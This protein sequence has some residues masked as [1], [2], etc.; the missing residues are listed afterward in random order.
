VLGDFANSTGDPA[1][2]GTLREVLAVELGKLPRLRVLSDART[3]E[4]QRLMV[5]AAEV[6]LT[7][8]IGSEICE[9]TGSAAVVEGSIS[10][11]GLQI[12]P[13]EVNPY[14][15]GLRVPK[16]LLGGASV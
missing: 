2:D 14:R 5:R 1:F 16:Q 10:R 13:N 7:P 8:A 6:K 3:S 15:S 9:R 12:Y 4:T 11:L